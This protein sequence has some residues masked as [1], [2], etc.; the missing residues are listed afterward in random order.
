MKYAGM[1]IYSEFQGESEKKVPIGKDFLFGWIV[2]WTRD[3]RNPSI[4]GRAGIDADF[5]CFVVCQN[6][7]TT[8]R[9]IWQFV[10]D[11][12]RIHETAEQQAIPSEINEVHFIRAR[13]LIYDTYETGDIELVVELLNPP[14]KD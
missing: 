12:F 1:E 2:E 11:Q 6:E 5:G 13:R 14:L 4:S 7:K 9:K 8:E 3:N 10:Q